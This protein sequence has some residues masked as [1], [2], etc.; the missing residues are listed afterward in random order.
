MLALLFACSEYGFHGRPLDTAVDGVV[1]PWDDVD[2]GNLPE[3]ALL[4]V[5]DDVTG[6]VAKDE[7]GDAYPCEAGPSSWASVNAAPRLD[8][9]DVRGQ[10]IG[11]IGVPPII[12]WEDPHV[13]AVGPREALLDGRTGNNGRTVWDV[14]VDALALTELAVWDPPRVWVGGVGRVTPNVNDVRFTRIGRTLYALFQLSGTSIAPTLDTPTLWAIDLD[15]PSATER[16]WTIGDLLPPEVGS[17][18]VWFYA[19]D[20]AASDGELAMQVTFLGPAWDGSDAAADWR[21]YRLVYL[22]ATDRRS[23]TIDL[24]DPKLESWDPLIHRHDAGHRAALVTEYD[25]LVA[26]P[27]LIL[28]DTTQA[29][30]RIEAPDATCLRGQAVLDADAP[31]IAYTRH[32]PAGPDDYGDRVGFLHGEAEVWGFDEIRVGLGARRGQVRSFVVLTP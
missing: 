8:L 31:T 9:L 5:W 1:G 6:V 19:R 24:S 27:G 25:Y 21:Y 29:P 16:V 18:G 10:V 3:I 30:R 28:F 12:P 2:P 20:L 32:D 26:D 13:Q 14:D 7:L 11:E 4:T 15:D 17:G 22:P 23:W